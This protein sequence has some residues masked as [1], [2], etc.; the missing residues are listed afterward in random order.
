MDSIPALGMGIRSGRFLVI[1][2]ET[3]DGF[4]FAMPTGVGF[5]VK[6]PGLM[7][8]VGTAD[9]FIFPTN[10]VFTPVA[11]FGCTPRLTVLI[12]IASSRKTAA[13]RQTVTNLDNISSPASN[14]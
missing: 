3:M 12:K 9:G 8:G 10:G 7:V 14:E 2:P 1:G 11:W 5:I 4:W 6:V 13:N